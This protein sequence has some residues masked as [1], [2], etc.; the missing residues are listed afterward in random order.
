MAA[1][2][3][4]VASIYSINGNPTAGTQGVVNSF[5][6]A[7]VMFYQN[8]PTSLVGTVTMNSVIVLL[9]SGLNQPIAKYLTDSTTTQLATNGS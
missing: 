5:P 6:S 9:P 7:Q 8:N 2:S 3:R 1:L 4:I